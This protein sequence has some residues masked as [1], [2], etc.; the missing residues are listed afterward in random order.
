[1]N[2]LEEL[3]SKKATVAVLAILISA[4]L[5][6]TLISST[7]TAYATNVEYYD[8][9]VGNKTI[10]V[11]GSE[12]DAK[13]IVDGVK[14]YY[15]TEGAEVLAVSCDPAITIKEHT[16]NKSNDKLPKLAKDKQA[17][18]D[19][20]IAGEVTTASYTVKEGDTI[21]DICEAKGLSVNEL[22]ELNKSVDVENIFVG[23]TLE[24]VEVEPLIE[25]TTEMKLTSEKSIPYETTE[26][27]TDSLYADQTE[28]KTEGVNGLKDVTEEIKSVNGNVVES[29]ELKSTVKK[30]AVNA[31]VLKGTKSRPS[32]TRANSSSYGG[33]YSYG[34]GA[35]FAGS[36]SAIASYALQF[37]GNPYAWGGTSLT[38]GA[39][40][41]GFVYA[42]YRNCGYSIPRVGQGSV[43]RSVPYSQ[44]VA[45]DI[46]IYPGH[47]SI[48][49]GGGREV[50]AVNE[51]VGITVTSTGYTGPILDVRRVVE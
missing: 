4:V 48:Y 12:S 10:A 45:G 21:W 49:I 8:I 3:K 29:K 28:V 24:F 17:V 37:V 1:M 6:I 22:A 11:V 34:G 19:H 46:L 41:S 14:N 27:T 43:G 9:K 42:V 26:E 38:N 40:C 16:Y 20:I 44:A 32:A 5:S 30:E 18:I 2:F 15:V 31:V 50:H 23:D 39:D 36:G 25:V 35:T 51:R 47:V 13:A 7:V 33:G